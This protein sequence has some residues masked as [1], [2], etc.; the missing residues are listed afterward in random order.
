[1][2]RQI[3]QELFA[4]VKSVDIDPNL[5]E[6]PQDRSMGDFALPCFSFAKELKKSPQDIAQMIV[7]ELN[8][9]EHIQRIEA[10]GPYVNVSLDS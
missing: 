4:Q 7:D 10:L 8:P 6:I 1:M 5:V 2:F 9:G 3:V